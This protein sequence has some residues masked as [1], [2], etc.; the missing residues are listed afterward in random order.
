V[1]R[2]AVTGDRTVA[3][4]QRVPE[5]GLAIEARVS[6]WR[7]TETRYHTSGLVALSA[8]L[9][10]ADLLKPYTLATARAV[11]VTD[12][13]QPDFTGVVVDARGSKASA[14]WAP[15]VLDHHGEVL[16]DGTLWE[17]AA[18]TATPVV[19]VSD[20][21]HPAAT[22]AGEAPL[23]LK[24]GEASGSDLLLTAEDSQRFRTSLNG[25]LLLGEGKLV[26]VVDP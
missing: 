2:I 18:I 5:F 10:L 11:V 19:F 6:R 12:S 21:A 4:L 13:P 16:Y 23:F 1:D 8:E 25:A 7:A 24:C 26:I 9:A 20:P 15:R 22:R 14:A 17:E 3:D